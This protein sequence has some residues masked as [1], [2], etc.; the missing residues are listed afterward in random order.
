MRKGIRVRNIVLFLGLAVFS[1]WTLF[2]FLWIVATSIKPDR[3]L[4]RKVSLWPATITDA[5]YIEVLFE[6]PFLT[7]FKNSFLVAT[8]TTAVAMVVA[9]LAAY[10]MTRPPSAAVPSSPGPPS[11]P[12]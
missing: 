4:Y 1:V 5:H 12:T 8:A 6:T 7:Y 3:D 10:A 2:P 9:V 11:S